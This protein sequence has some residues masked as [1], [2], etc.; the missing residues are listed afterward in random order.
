MSYSVPISNSNFTT[1]A[2]RG[3]DRQPTQQGDAENAENIKQFL[4]GIP[5]GLLPTNNSTMSERQ[6]K[7]LVVQRLEQLFTGKKRVIGMNTQ[8]AQQQE[9]AASAAR[10]DDVAAN[11]SAQADGV[12]EAHMLPTSADVDFKPGRLPTSSSREDLNTTNTSS[13]DGCG[14]DDSEIEQRPT[15]PLDLDPDRAQVAAENVEYLRHLG[16]STP[17]LIS[18]DSSDAEPD[19]QGWIYLNLLINMAQLHIINVTPDF[20]RKAVQEVSD[21]LQL[22][23]DGHKLRWRGGSKGTRFSSIN[24][25]SSGSPDDSDSVKDETHVKRR[26]LDGGRFAAVP[27]NVE[28]QYSA[29]GG[30]NSAKLHYRPMFNHK[31]SATGSSISGSTSLISRH[32]DMLEEQSLGPRS[33][34]SHSAARMKRPRD[35]GTMVFYSNAQFCTDLSGDRHIPTPLY[36]GLRKDGYI[37]AVHVLGMEGEPMASPYSPNRHSDRHTPPSEICKAS[38]SSSELSVYGAYTSSR[39]LEDDQNQGV[40]QSFEACGL[41]GTQPADHFTI[42]CQTGRTRLRSP[43]LVSKFSAPT[44]KMKRF[45]HRVSTSAL[46]AFSENNGGRMS[47]YPAVQLAPSPPRE[48]DSFIPAVQTK[49]LSATFQRLPPSRLPDPTGYYGTSSNSDDGESDMGAYTAAS[50]VYKLRNADSPR[51]RTAASNAP[52]QI[53][54]QSVKDK[55]IGRAQEKMKEE[56]IEEGEDC[57]DDDDMSIDMLGHMRDVDPHAVAAQE[58]AFDMANRPVEMDVAVSAAATIAESDEEFWG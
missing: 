13:S 5:E 56:E 10:A 48:S 29:A 39:S 36:A 50:S 43:S 14:S 18:E 49:Y 6:K 35:D 8:P 11:R 54:L 12:R 26:K 20:V 42:Q 7:T 27:V 23:K 47:S 51:L 45:L 30:H 40:P 37:N 21:K 41:G 28:K 3:K 15:R 17:Q 53:W 22:S 2:F 44:A 55:S 9:V 33:G 4:Q 31:D 34:I 52:S 57:D 38:Q 19:A 32:N 1:N 24:S 46:D 58:E 25:G 16:L